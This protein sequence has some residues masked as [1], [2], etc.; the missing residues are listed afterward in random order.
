M[1]IFANVSWSIFLIPPLIIAIP[2]FIIIRKTILKND[3]P[4]HNPGP[5][6]KRLTAFIILFTS[7]IVP[8]IIL[9]HFFIDKIR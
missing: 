6:P 9:Y 5:T 4:T 1:L 3:D 2:V 8:A 7:Y